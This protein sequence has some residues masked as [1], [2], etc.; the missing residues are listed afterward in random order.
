MDRKSPEYKL[1]RAHIYA[2]DNWKCK[3]CLDNKRLEAHH[4]YPVRIYKEL[5]LELDNG[6]T[7]C[8]KC[9]R[10]IAGKEM[11]FANYFK[12]LLANGVN[13]VK[14]LPGNAGDNTEPTHK[15]NFMKGVTTRRR[16][17]ILEQFINKHIPCSQCHKILERHY[18]RTISTKNHFCSTKCKSLFMKGKNTGKDN[19]RYKEKKASICLFCN[20][21]TTTPTDSSRKKKFCNNSCQLKYEYRNGTRLRK[22]IN[23][24]TKK[25]DSCIIC[26]SSKRRHYGKSK[27]MKC[28]NKEYVSNSPKKTLPERD[29]IV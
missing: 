25:L 11:Q 19:V 15:G 24:W 17:Y 9:H 5:S 28:Y 14:L 7:L 6:I 12:G 13:S 22:K 27:C 23:T 1:W 3:I 26:K 2:R 21:E 16:D 20:K 29:D 8:F 18:Y 4:I 10:T